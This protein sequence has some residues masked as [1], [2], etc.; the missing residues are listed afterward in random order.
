MGAGAVYVDDSG[1]P[2]QETGSDFL[3][4]SRKSW[5]GVIVPSAVAADVM[6]AMD[7]F[8][9]GVRG[10]FGAEEL[11]FTDVF[12]GKGPWR[13][14]PV[15]QRIEI[16]DL[17]SGL[18]SSFALPVIHVTTSAETL[19]EPYCSKIQAITSTP[20]TTSQTAGKLLPC[21]NGASSATPAHKANAIA[22]NVNAVGMMPKN[23]RYSRGCLTQ[24]TK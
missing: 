11:H 19:L 8:L 14:V 18:M 20:A 17:M 22:V 4:S 15:G 24:S 9:T 3:P 10:D 6:T 12:S 23:G 7:M 1:N 2:G 21:V 5:T 16:F 13:G